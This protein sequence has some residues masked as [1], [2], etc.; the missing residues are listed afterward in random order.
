M[1]DNGFGEGEIWARRV[2]VSERTGRMVSMISGDGGRDRGESSVEV[3]F[4]M[5]LV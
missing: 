3:R 5:S 1:A 2:R 4:C